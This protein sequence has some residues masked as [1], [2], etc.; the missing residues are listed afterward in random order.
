[1]KEFLLFITESFK[2]DKK[3]LNSAKKTSSK[4]SRM[5][6]RILFDV[7]TTAKRDVHENRRKV[8]LYDAH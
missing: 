8:V 5:G 2:K 3:S 1:M 6:L 7:F 4:F